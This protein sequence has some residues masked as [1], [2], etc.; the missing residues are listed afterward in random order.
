MDEK[1]MSL[2][3]AVR[4]C[5]SP[6]IE[7]LR[8][9]LHWVRLRN[10]RAIVRLEEAVRMTSLKLFGR[11]GCNPECCQSEGNPVP[12]SLAATIEAVA[13]Q[14]DQIHELISQLE[15]DLEAI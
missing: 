8:T 7:T 5:C 14:S 15:K 10:A 13:N 4:E 9:R 12:E 11:W 3:C 1:K 2:E 6:S